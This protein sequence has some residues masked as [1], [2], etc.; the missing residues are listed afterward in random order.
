VQ[1]PPKP[2]RKS[3]ARNVLTVMSGTFSSRLLGLLRQTLFNQFETRLTDAFNVAYNIPNL[4]RELLAE[5]ALSNSIIPVYKKLEPSE[6]KAFIGSFMAFLIF[7]NALVVSAGIL[8]APQLVDL[9]LLSNV[10]GAGN[11]K[12]DLELTIFLTRLTMPFLMGISFSALA[13]GLLNAEERFGATAFAP[14]AFNLVTILGLLLFPNNPA[15]LGIMTSLGGLA[16]LL[17][18]LPSLQRFGLLPAPRLMWHDGLSRALSLMAPFAFTTSTRIFLG[19]I[20]TGLLTGFG[21]GAITGF[22]NAEVIFLMLQGLFA[23]SPATA[24]Y[25]R[26]SEYAAAQD[27]DAFRETVSSYARL[28][29][30]LSVGVGALLWALAPHITSAIFELPGKITDD[31]FNATLELL[32]SFALA[33]APWGLVQL[34]TRAFYAREKSRDAVVISTVAFALNT[35]LYIGLAPR[36]I[37]AMNFATAITGWLMVGVYVAVLHKQ[38]DLNYKKLVGHTIKVALAALACFFAAQVVSSLLPSARN[39]FNG[40]LHCVV[41]GGLGG[42]VYVLGCVLLRVPEVERITRRLKK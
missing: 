19:V 12:L 8:F 15:M 26:F 27:W 5:G 21:E 30:F 40:I 1:E 7:I 22:R 36:G 20:L 17:V 32:P 28:V 14:L 23:V 2:I 33:I 25:P 18:Q 3:A 31:K 11:N 38:I 13:M 24:A 34:L 6:R 42:L 10:L 9:M 39:A 16:Q 41:A 4:F 29:L 35:A 37:V